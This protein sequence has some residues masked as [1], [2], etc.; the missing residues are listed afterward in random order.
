MLKPKPA[1]TRREEVSAGLG[2]RLIFLL[3]ASKM[4]P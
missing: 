3:Y 2:V 1:E 4:E